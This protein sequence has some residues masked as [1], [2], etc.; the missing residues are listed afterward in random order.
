[1]RDQQDNWSDVVWEWARRENPSDEVFNAVRQWFD[2]CT[3]VGPPEER[4]MLHM[5]GHT[6]AAL[7]GWNANVWTELHIDEANREIVVASLGY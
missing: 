3:A 6:Y 2:R 5:G 4:S 1:M 7:A